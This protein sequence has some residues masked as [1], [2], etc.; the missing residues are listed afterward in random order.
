[1]PIKQST[2]TTTVTSDFGAKFASAT[3]NAITFTVDPADGGANFNVSLHNAGVMY[4]S[5]GDVIS[6]TSDYTYTQSAL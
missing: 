2:E 6:S 1:M 5:K 3:G 4:A